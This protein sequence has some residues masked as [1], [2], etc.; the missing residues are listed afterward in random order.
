[1]EHA[2]G[3][4]QQQQDQH[5]RQVAVV[6][7]AQQHGGQQ[8]GHQWQQ[9]QVQ[10]CVQRVGRDQ[11]CDACRQPQQRERAQRRAARRG[12]SGPGFA[13]GQ[14]ETDDDGCGEPEQ[15]FVR[16]PQQRRHRHRWA[17]PAQHDGHPQRNRQCGERSRAQVKRPKAQAQKW[18]AARRRRSRAGRGGVENDEGW[19][20]HGV[21]QANWI[22]FGLSLRCM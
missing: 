3:G 13:R 10:R 4:G 8:R 20:A 17:D 21:D 14:Q 1:M 12:Q 7:G 22:G 15:H 5:Q 2:V 19:G 11:C 18:Q 6:A 9:Q 16:V